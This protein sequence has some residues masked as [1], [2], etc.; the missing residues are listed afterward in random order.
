MHTVR[1]LRVTPC[2]GYTDIGPMTAVQIQTGTNGRVYKRAPN[3]TPCYLAWVVR[4][5]VDHALYA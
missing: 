4:G 1:H 3:M 5:N 2:D